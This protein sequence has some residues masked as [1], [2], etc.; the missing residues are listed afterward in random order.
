MALSF[1]SAGEGL[2][3]Q[4]P[5]AKKSGKEG[6]EHNVM[7]KATRVLYGR[8]AWYAMSVVFYS[9]QSVNRWVYDQDPLTPVSYRIGPHILT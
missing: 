5:M 8:R 2:V 6:S 3:K 7:E 1:E 4:G 9:G